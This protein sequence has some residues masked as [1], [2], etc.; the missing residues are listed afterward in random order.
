MVGIEVIDD[1]DGSEGI[2]I[3]ID[4]KSAIQQPFPASLRNLGLEALDNLELMLEE[5][6]IRQDLATVAV[7]V[8]DEG[9]LDMVGAGIARGGLEKH[10]FIKT[11][12]DVLGGV[13]EVLDSR[14]EGVDGESR[15]LGEGQVRS[16][17]GGERG[18][19]GVNGG[20]VGGDGL[21]GGFHLEDGVGGVDE[22]AVPVAHE[23]P[24]LLLLLLD[25]QLG[26]GLHI[27]DF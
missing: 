26:C 20:D 4:A 6:E 25:L 17:G 2:C 8:V 10:G 23:L 27:A 5:R 3:G 12:P 16:V 13:N 21:A 11:T 14:S 1:G 22:V 18:N 7:G 24:E 15:G 9:G 19:G